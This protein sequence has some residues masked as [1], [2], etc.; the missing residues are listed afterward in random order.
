MSIC[1]VPTQRM[2]QMKIPFGFFFCLQLVARDNL[3]AVEDGSLFKHGRR[4]GGGRPVSRQASGGQKGEGDWKHR[5]E[6]SS[7]FCI[8]PS[9][10]K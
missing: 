7:C 6:D 8:P 2:R 4:S 5:G 1:L 3:T 9:K 10:K